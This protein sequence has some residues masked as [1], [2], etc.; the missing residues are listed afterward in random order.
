[1]SEHTGGHKLPGQ[2]E[3]T[4]VTSIALEHSRLR[5]LNAHAAFIAAY[6]RLSGLASI[7]PRPAV[8]VA[9]VNARAR[10]VEAVIVEAGHSLILGRH[11]QCGL[12]LPDETLSLRQ[13]VLHASSETAGAAPLIRLWDLNTGRPFITEDGQPNVAVIA[14][15]ALYASVGEYAL[16]FIPTLGPA[17]TPWPARAEEAWKALPPREFIDRRRADAARLSRS[18]RVRSD[19]RDYVTDIFRVR[20][21]HDTSSVS[22]VGPLLMLGEDVAPEHAWGVLLLEQGKKVSKL[23]ISLEHLD[24]G[25][26]LGRYDRC[27]IHLSGA[28]GVSRVHLLL[29][30][31]G[32]EVLAID[33]ASTNGTW[34]GKTQIQTEVLG[35]P[36]SLQVSDDVRVYWRR[37]APSGA[38]SRR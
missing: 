24:Q 28:Q 35:D 30:R 31:S 2:N 18:R 16:L 14:E 3:G 38:G 12:R 33:T 15:G 34:R 36:D 21:E 1:M 11:T 29:V 19:G 13:L 4:Q 25:V 10:V 8:L 37:M 22:R 5:P 6:D 32:D 7:A 17:G 26:L 9:A 20:E 23:H 27:G